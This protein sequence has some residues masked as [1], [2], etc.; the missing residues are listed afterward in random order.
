V[1]LYASLDEREQAFAALERA[2]AAHDL[3]LQHLNVDV[4]FDDL[5]QDPR[6]KD[7]MRRVGLPS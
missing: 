4:S 6:F 5:R 7:L 2:Y 3:Q 1:V